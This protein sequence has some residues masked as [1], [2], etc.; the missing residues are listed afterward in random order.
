MEVLPTEKNSKYLDIAE[1]PGR[2]R[3]YRH[4]IADW[5]F[6]RSTRAILI[7]VVSRD[8]ME[9]HARKYRYGTMPYATEAISSILR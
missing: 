9:A 6:I 2:V 1:S 7:S 5:V 8:S 4:A 3:S